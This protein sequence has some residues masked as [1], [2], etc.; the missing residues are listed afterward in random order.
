[1]KRIAAFL[2]LIQLALLS[3]PVLAQQASGAFG[4]ARTVAT[5]SWIEEW[6]AASGQWVRVADGSAAAV[7]VPAAS[8]DIPTMTTTFVNGQQVSETHTAARYAQPAAQ[9]RSDAMI[10]QYGPFVVTSDT[11]AAMM[12]STD[13]ASPAHFDAM[14]RD[15]PQITILE[16]IEAPGTSNDIANLAVGR[17]IRSAGIATH[18]PNG[19]SVRSGAVEL[20]LAGVT[21]TVDD[22]AQFAV[23]SW[24]DNY[25]REA[26][27]FAAE[28]A[29]HRLYLD[30]Y[31]EMGMSELRARDFYAMTNSVPHA[32]ALWLSAP[33]MRPWLR[34]ERSPAFRLADERSPSGNPSERDVAGIAILAVGQPIMPR[35]ALDWD[36]SEMAARPALLTPPTFPAIDYSDISA[37]TLAQLDADIGAKFHLS[38]LDSVRAFP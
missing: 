4:N 24:L 15:F 5:E 30:Y 11:R 32:E 14:L 20:F 33:E 26:D 17:R 12:G 35:I 16:M 3:S 18:V 22:G 21:R 2:A 19:G 31:V 6:D 29:A 36:R 1:M 9:P 37:I 25:G 27:D 10:A 38:R 13:S 23:H 8:T 28:D 7:T 34:P